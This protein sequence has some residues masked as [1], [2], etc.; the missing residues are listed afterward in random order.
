VCFPPPLV[1]EV[2]YS[3]S[4]SFAS[5]RVTGRIDFRGVFSPAQLVEE[6]TFFPPLKNVD[7]GLLWIKRSQFLLD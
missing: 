1:E 2:E 7:G 3:N 6:R 5:F 4:S